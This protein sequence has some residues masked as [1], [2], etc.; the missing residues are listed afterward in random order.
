MKKDGK[1]ISMEHVRELERL[2]AGQ[3]TLT[4]QVVEMRVQVER[5]FATGDEI[6][7]NL[8]EDVGLINVSM[9]KIEDKMSKMPGKALVWTLITAQFTLFGLLIVNMLLKLLG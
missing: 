7:K 1:T 3:S 9:G 2:S 8:K 4:N 6:M 5:R